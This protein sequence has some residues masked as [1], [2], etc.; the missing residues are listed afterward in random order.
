[1]VGL[2]FLMLTSL[3]FVD[4]GRILL[5]LPSLGTLV[6]CILP[7]VPRYMVEGLNQWVLDMGQR[8]LSANRS[9]HSLGP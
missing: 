6:R 1:M 3:F 8:Y 2:M 5:L 9:P 4:T 7:A